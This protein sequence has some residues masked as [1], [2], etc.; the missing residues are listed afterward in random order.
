MEGEGL[1][2]RRVVPDDLCDALVAVDGEY[3]IDT[4][5]LPNG[6]GRPPAA[7]VKRH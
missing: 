5:G 3:G 2:S 7:P 4:T 6:R 1:A